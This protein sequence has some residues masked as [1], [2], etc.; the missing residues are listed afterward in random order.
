[1][2]QT[3]PSVH[4]LYDR[5][6]VIDALANP[7]S[8]N[9]P[10]PP[11]YR[12]LSEEQVAS[13]RASGITAINVTV[14]EGAAD[15]SGFETVVSHIAF[16]M[17]EVQRNPQVFSLILRGADIAAAKHSGRVGLMLG[18]QGTDVL[19][20]DLER[21]VL[22]RRF[23]VRIMQLTYNT[24]SLVGDGCLEP[25]NAGL[26][27]FGRTAVK[28][29]NELG[30][31]VDLGH[32]GAQTCLD[33]IAVSSKPVLITHTG[34]R[35]VF[36]HPRNK[37][38]EVLRATVAK[39]GVVGIFLMPFLGTPTTKDLVLKHIEHAVQICGVDGVGI[40]SDQSI[41]PIRE[42]AE[43]M[44]ALD[45][46]GRARRAAGAAAPGEDTPPY[47]KELNSPRRLEMIAEALSQ[48]GYKDDDLAKILGGNFHRVLREIWED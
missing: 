44:A 26:S 35:A 24:R 32:C 27:A 1:V 17:S 15:F 7:Q 23:G 10:W 40:G 33:A 43:Y 36:D 39:R 6:V 19:G 48:R 13:A 20:T 45:A 21:L 9:V 46:I 34:C 37:S 30:I 28:R 31:A 14:N 4:S 25:G 41:T 47:S 38:D 42:T 5:S 18:F 12:G 2:A 29:M 22:F 8:F 16:W 11:Q 3:A